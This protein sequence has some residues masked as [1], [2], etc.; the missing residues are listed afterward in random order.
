MKWKHSEFLGSHSS[1]KAI[2]TKDRAKMMIS[3]HIACAC[4]LGKET[5]KK[6]TRGLKVL[7]PSRP[8]HVWAVSYSRWVNCY[9]RGTFY[10]LGCH[11]SRSFLNALDFLICLRHWK[12]GS[13]IQLPGTFRNVS[14]ESPSRRMAGCVFQLC[15]LFFFSDPSTTSSAILERTLP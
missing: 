5:R 3:P 8:T 7:P 10:A 9:H 6:S 15:S 11:I 13:V 1:H 12:A 4:V 14:L 2:I